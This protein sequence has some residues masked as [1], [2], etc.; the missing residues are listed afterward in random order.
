LQVATDAGL[1]PDHENAPVLRGGLVHGGDAHVPAV[2]D[3]TGVGEQHLAR[4]GEA[5]GTGLAHE[6]RAPEMMLEQSHLPRQGGL[7]HVQPLG[8][9]GEVELLGDGDEV[10]EVTQVDVH[11]EALSQ[12]VLDVHRFYGQVVG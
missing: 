12:G 7:G 11:T 8:R 1:D 10:A 4:G 3:V 9:P 5:D 6:Q 2:Q